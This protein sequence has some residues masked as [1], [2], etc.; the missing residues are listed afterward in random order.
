MTYNLSTRIW[1]AKI[2][3][4]W[5]KDWSKP[6]TTQNQVLQ[7]LAQD[8][9]ARTGNTG[10]VDKADRFLAEITSALR[11]EMAELQTLKAEQAESLERAVVEAKRFA[12]A[13]ELNL[14]STEATGGKRTLLQVLQ[15]LDK[16]APN[17]SVPVNLLMVKECLI[18]DKVDNMAEAKNTHALVPWMIELTNELFK[19]RER[20]EVEGSE[21]LKRAS[22]E[23]RK[24]QDDQATSFWKLR[25]ELLLEL[26][27]LEKL[28]AEPE[29]D[30]SWEKIPKKDYCGRFDVKTIFLS[31]FDADSMQKVYEACKELNCNAFV[32]GEQNGV[33]M[34]WLKR[35]RR[36]GGS[37]LPDDS[38]YTL[39]VA[40]Y[41]EEIKD[42]VFAATCGPRN[43]LLV[44]PRK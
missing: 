10:Y 17:Q 22:E 3:T 19:Q 40:S 31:S 36:G 38:R 33:K 8:L 15:E 14:E 41:L 13:L 7:D 6:E 28:G 16:L 43:G 39:Y 44:E 12:A 21:G 23:R 27:K 37:M 24:W 1:L 29:V 34:A 4:D 9:A 11:R 18:S 35:V 25:K 2:K 42:A 32:L 20:L 5:L 26:Q 30:D